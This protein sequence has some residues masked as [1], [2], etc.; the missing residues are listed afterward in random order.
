M[1][2]GRPKKEKRKGG[3]KSTEENSTPFSLKSPNSRRLY[4][5]HAQHKS[6]GQTA[7]YPS[8]ESSLP[9]ASSN[10]IGPG[11]PQKGPGRPA[12]DPEAGPMSPDTLGD[13][14]RKLGRLNYKRKKVS[15]IRREAVKM[16][17]DRREAA[18]GGDIGSADDSFHQD[19]EEIREESEDDDAVSEDDDE[20][21]EDRAVP[22]SLRT[23]SRRRKEFV[24]L[25][26]ED[27]S[28]SREVLKLLVKDFG[29][30]ELLIDQ[31]KVHQCESEVH[32]STMYRHKKRASDFLKLIQIKHNISPSAFLIFAAQQQLL[33]DQHG[34]NEAGISFLHHADIPEPIRVQ[35]IS[36][37][38]ATLLIR[39]RKHSDCRRVS[40]QHAIGVSKEAGLNQ[41]GGGISS[42]AS[43]I[44]STRKF[45][46]KVL[47]AVELEKTESLFKRQNR[48]N[49]IC[50]TDIPERLIEFL[51]NAEHSRA[52]PGNETVSVAYG[53]RLPKFLLKKSKSELADLFKKE[54]PD[55]TFSTRIL[56][57]EWPANFV[58]PSH[59]DQERN[60]CPLHSNLR[61]CHDGLRQVG[62]AGDLPRSVRAM[63][64]KTMCQDKEFDPLI[65]ISWPRDCAL[66][67]CKKC[68]KLSVTLPENRSAMVTFLQWK[69]G[70][71]SK[72]DQKG[73]PK[74]ITSLFPVFFELDAAVQYFQAFFP[75]IKIHVYVA[76][77][78]YEALRLRSCSLSLGD[79]LT[80]EDYT[81]NFD[82]QYSETTTSSHY[83]ANQVTFAGYPIAVRY[84]DPG[85]LKLAKGAILFIS[86]DKSH[87]FEQVEMFE[88]RALE[89][90]QEKCGQVITCWNRWSDNCASQFKSKNTLGRL[91][92]ARQKVLLMVETSLRIARYPGT[93]LRPMRPK[94]NL[95]PLE[96]SVKLP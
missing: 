11:S 76:S 52:L 58:P 69:K 33:E 53:K 74:E 96:D 94:M 39:D 35:M 22:P 56:I 3:R 30:K 7:V 1:A 31:D 90:C 13:R 67:V 81:M 34:F 42:L 93:F 46:S 62:A 43:A 86:V 20:G 17:A 75:K 79:L 95:I 68:P 37:D 6:R 59:K 44:G 40:L 92:Q 16:R 72:C 63:C 27:P 71:S 61:R 2:G 88:R 91:V 49:S 51:S 50:S 77:M 78:Q 82:I 10:C 9:A 85:T 21:S 48:S 89:I 4:N 5:Q 18:G 65:P 70:K 28:F 73:N 47:K 36:D 25:L 41:T 29:V 84:M 66:G 32:R 80:I 64:A 55:I 57:R 54:N 23:V 87:D 15:D 60:V 83:T 19:G 38:L 24:S 45:A 12:L 8:A 14:K 26:P